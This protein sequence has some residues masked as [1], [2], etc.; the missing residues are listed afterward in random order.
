MTSSAGLIHSPSLK[1]GHN[2]LYQLLAE[3]RVRDLDQFKCSPQLLYCHRA[4][5]VPG[6]LRLSLR[7]ALRRLQSCRHQL[8]GGGGE[9]EKQTG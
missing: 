4:P 7:T 2:A 9:L 3:T 1:L 8:E 6:D 5:S